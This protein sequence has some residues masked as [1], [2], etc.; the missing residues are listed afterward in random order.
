MASSPFVDAAR[1]REPCYRQ[2]SMSAG[3]VTIVTP[4]RCS[5]PFSSADE[6]GATRKRGTT[7]KIPL[8]GEAAVA[9]S[10]AS[11]GQLTTS[12]AISASAPISDPASGPSLAL[13]GPCALYAGRS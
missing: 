7:D 11:W 10:A 8:L 12:A 4:A 5:A 3:L 6:L 9:I 2:I 13:F 1:M